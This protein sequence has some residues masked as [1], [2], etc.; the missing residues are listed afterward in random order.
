MVETMG[1]QAALPQLIEQPHQPGTDPG[2]MRMGAKSLQI[3][4]VKK[5][6]RDER[7]LKI[8]RITW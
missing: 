3:K 7:A 4:T 6:R 8:G 2:E 5:A 1:L